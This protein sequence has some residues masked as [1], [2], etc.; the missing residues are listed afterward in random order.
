[1]L[2]GFNHNVGHGGKTYH[3]Q[4]EDLGT[5]N[6]VVVTHLFCGGTVIATARA[7]YHDSLG[8]PDVAAHVMSLMQ[9]QHKQML[10][11]LVSGAYDEVDPR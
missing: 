6:P 4:T 2:P 8:A 1:M 3:V 9:D 11:R 7:G 5:S 10:R